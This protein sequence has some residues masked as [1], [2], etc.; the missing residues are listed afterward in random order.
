MEKKIS[1]RRIT[2][3]KKYFLEG[4][5]KT[6]GWESYLSLYC[7]LSADWLIA[8]YWS[9]PWAEAECW[10]G[11]SEEDNHT[12]NNL[13]HNPTGFSLYECIFSANLVPSARWRWSLA[14]WLSFAITFCLSVKKRWDENTNNTLNHSISNIFRDACHIRQ[15]WLFSRAWKSLIK[16]T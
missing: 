8:A 6:E 14:F 7:P 16:I 12:Q 13:E 9:C 11:L 15:R 5:T 1:S 4:A 2:D 10:T 3:K